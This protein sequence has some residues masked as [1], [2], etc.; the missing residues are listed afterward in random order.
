MQLRRCSV[1]GSSLVLE[2][3]GQDGTAGQSQREGHAQNHEQS[4]PALGS[5]SVLG[6]NPVSAAYEPRAIVTEPLH[7]LGVADWAA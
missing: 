1:A 7:S 2:K 4:K 5:W 3:R 6:S